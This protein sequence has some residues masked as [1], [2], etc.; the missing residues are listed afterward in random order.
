MFV[1]ETLDS[2][3][4]QSYQ[5]WECVIVDDGSTD[6]SAAIVKSYC[7]KDSRIAYLYQNNQGVAVARNHAIASS[8]GSLILPLD[9]DDIIAPPY[10]EKAAKILE[11]KPDV[12]VV[13]CL[14][15]KFGRKKG[16]WKLD[17]FDFKNLLT[18][19]QIFSS[20]LYRRSDFDKTN[21]YN[22]DMVGMED[23]DFWLSMLKTGG[24][25]VRINEVL[26]YYRTHKLSRNKMAVS[27][28]EQINRQ[29]YENH[30]EL[31][32]DF[33]D[34]P[35]QLVKEHARYKKYYDLFQKLTLKTLFSKKKPQ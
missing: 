33:I 16:P 22:P 9:A 29:I 5:N 20:A 26:F 21:G 12:K 27:K 13:Y 10:V 3:I 8:R 25:V 32:A 23:W 4:K 2:V 19:N 18:Q 14:A 7:E 34:N 35:I 30:K 31:Y 17:E 1:A 11:E 15:E 28:I 24:C 6:S